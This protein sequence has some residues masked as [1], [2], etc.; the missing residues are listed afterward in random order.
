MV[1]FTPRSAGPRRATTRKPSSGRGTWWTWAAIGAAIV[2]VIGIAASQILPLG[3][4]KAPAALVATPSSSGPV[5]FGVVMQVPDEGRTHVAEGSAIT[6]KTNP[7]ASGPHY[8]APGPWGISEQPL[9]PGYFVHN[10]EH[11]GVDVLYDCP[12][13]CQ[14]TIDVAKQ[15]LQTFPKDK[16][17]E[18]K[19]LVTPN[20][21]LP[22]GARVALL[23]W[24]IE[25]YFQGDLTLDQLKSF[26]DAHADKPCPT[27]GPFIACSPEDIP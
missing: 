20:N 25:E 12:N 17:N 11:G 4:T 24:D 1:S 18:V 5:Q 7:P 14:A 27:N 19:L 8:P 16:F 21:S 9:A 3:G 15:A 6:Y 10:L 23:A 26:Y 13:G 22:G 2:V